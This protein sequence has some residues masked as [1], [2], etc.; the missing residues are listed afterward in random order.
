MALGLAPFPLHDT[1][2]LWRP[3]NQGWLLHSPLRYL[4][5]RA[6][7]MTAECSTVDQSGFCHYCSC[8][9]CS[10]GCKAAHHR[11]ALQIAHGSV[12][13]QSAQRGLESRVANDT[14]LHERL[15]HLKAPLKVLSPHLVLLVG[16]VKAQFVTTSAVG[17][18]QEPTKL[19]SLR[20]RNGFLFYSFESC[21]AA[22][23]SIQATQP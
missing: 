20:N 23:Q 1:C 5:I 4:K 14:Q 19:P 15:L 9:R 7:S 8:C 12:C 18:R 11:R 6:H 16:W 2:C 22:V 13:A 3:L 17:W 21:F 10:Y